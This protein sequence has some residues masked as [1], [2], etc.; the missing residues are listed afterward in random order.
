[1]KSECPISPASPG[2]VKKWI[3]AARP[4]TL[5]AGLS[6]VWIGTAIASR[7][8]PISLGI[9]AL[10]LAVSLCLQIGANWANDYF[11]FIKGADTS[12]RKGLPRAA[13]AGWISP[14]VLKRAAYGAFLAASIFSLPLLWRIG[15]SHLP[16]VFLAIASG[17]FYTAGTRPLGYLGLGDLF[18]F[19]FFGVVATVYSTLAQLLFIPKEAW[20]A[21]FAPGCFSCAILSIN[22]LRDLDED[23]QANKLT[24]AVRFGSSFAIAQYYF[25]CLGAFLVPLVLVFLG[26]NVSL[27]ALLPLSIL[28]KKPLSLVASQTRLNQALAATAILFFLYTAAFHACLSI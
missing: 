23:R 28:F 27:L 7:W 1:M 25:Y 26:M 3:L 22:N 15:F 6:P 17:I 11:D 12:Q 8:Q 24:L 14:P 19:A 18:V 16:L 2:A 21:S 4:Y 5:I 13:Q 9:L 10:C 20:I